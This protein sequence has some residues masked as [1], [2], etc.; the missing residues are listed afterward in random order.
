MLVVCFETSL[1][2]AS[3]EC[4]LECTM[5]SNERGIQ[6]SLDDGSG[7]S[8]SNII[9]IYIVLYIYG[10]TTSAM[11]TLMFGG[12]TSVSTPATLVIILCQIASL[13]HP[14]VIYHI[15]LSFIIIFLSTTPV[16]LYHIHIQDVPG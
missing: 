10:M 2:A 3:L 1:K 4:I 9:Y 11:A 14:C 16:S 15:K 8:S 7:C 12:V 5:V 13:S 6:L